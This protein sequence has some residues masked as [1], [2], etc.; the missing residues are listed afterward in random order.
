[1]SVKLS[2][3][4]HN[5]NVVSLKYV[6]PVLSRR[7]GGL[8][9]G[10]NFNSNN[11]CNWRCIY[12]QVPNLQK[13]SAPAMDFALLKHEL[14][15]FFNDVLHGDFYQ[16][17]AVP[18][19]QQQIKDIAISGNG[20]PSSLKNFAEAIE[21]IATVATQAGI[22]PTSK[23]VLITNGSLMHQTPVQAGLK[24]LNFYNGE[25]WFKLDSATQAGITQ[26]NNANLSPQKQLANLKICAK[27]CITSLQTCLVNYNEQ[28]FAISEQQAYL[29]LLAEL[30]DQVEIKDIMLYSIARTSLQPEAALLAKISCADME[31]FANKIR[32]MHFKVSV[33]S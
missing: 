7:A 33:N 21:I 19:E 8:S 28:G 13:G 14:K 9:I 16:R 6:Y 25:V 3:T 27:L 17:F 32:N 2:I 18:L 15:L 20:E 23:L 5:R 4:D 12:C 11:A 24:I 26:L 10:I 1:M 30:Q 22:L 31:I 29:N